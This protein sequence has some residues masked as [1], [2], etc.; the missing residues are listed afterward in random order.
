MVQWID[1]RDDA[2]VPVR[3]G[4]VDTVG[5]DEALL[6]EG[7]GVVPVGHAVAR[8]R[9]APGMS[10]HPVGCACCAPRGPV[11]E[12]LGRLFVARAR[13]EAAFFRAV[14]AVVATPAGEAAVRAALAEDQ[15][16]AGR[17]RPA[18]GT[19]NAPRRDDR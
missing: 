16:C 3:F 8:F 17:F 10:G 13:G 2:R 15:V 1:G 4:A 11:A 12:T 19:G 18:V 5:P 14:V 6:V 9:L 7:D